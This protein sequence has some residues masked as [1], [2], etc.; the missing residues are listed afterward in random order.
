MSENLLSHRRLHL[1]IRPSSGWAALKIR[2]LWQFRDLLLSLAGRDLK[3]RYKQTALGVVWVVLQPLLQ[4]G[5]FSIVFG[6]VAGMDKGNLP[7][8]YFLLTFCGQLAWNMFGW[9]VLK[10]SECLLNNSQLVSKVF[11]PRLV[12]PLATAFSTIVDVLVC[13]V[14]LGVLLACFRLT[15]G[16]QVLLFPLWSVLLLLLG[17]GM[18]LIASALMV[19]YRDVKYVL[20]VAVQTLMF[21]CPVMYPAAKAPAEWRWFFDINPLT[22]LIE[23]FRYSLLAG[24]PAPNWTLAGISAVATLAV[25]VFG[26]FSFKR[27]ERRFA[28]VI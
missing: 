22:P 2:E 18:G 7:Y 26:L 8:P 16:V 28:D 1:V 14:V 9:T 15:P 25:F 23:G 5:I 27:M 21:A 20:P 10:S 24:A 3:V 4:A 6:K 19:T 13:M 11:F 12:L 17:L